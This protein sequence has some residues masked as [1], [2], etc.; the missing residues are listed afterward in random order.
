[1]RLGRPEGM[2]QKETKRM[3]QSNGGD[4][5]RKPCLEKGEF[6]GKST[7]LLLDSQ[8]SAKGL[9]GLGAKY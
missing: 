2:C 4:G 8:A 5:S 6:R 1:M 9:L 3:V 7:F